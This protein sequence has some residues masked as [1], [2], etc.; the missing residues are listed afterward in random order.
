MAKT[1]RDGILYITYGEKY[2]RAAIRSAQSAR[3]HSPDLGMH[4]WVDKPC[5]DLFDLASNP[6]PF[7]S[8]GIIEHPHRRSK[9]DYISQTPFERTLYMDSDTT[10]AQDISEVFGVLERFDIGAIHA[11]RRNGERAN[12]FWTKPIT[13]AYPHFNGG[14]I[15][16]RNTPKV[17]ALLK[18]WGEAFAKSGSQHDQATLRELL[19]DSDL[20][21]A[22]LP[23]EYNVRYMKYKYLW[24]KSEATPMIYHLKSYHRDPLQ[25]KL[26]WTVNLVLKPFGIRWATIA[27]KLGIRKR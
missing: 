13:P 6:A 16:Y 15:L 22:T 5:Y 18:A 19:W 17:L 3:L 7:T 21:V 1:Y 27:R 20:Q 2:V 10:V 23:P 8:V 12:E 24:G 26:I 4:L 25:M 14:I 9:V 11:M